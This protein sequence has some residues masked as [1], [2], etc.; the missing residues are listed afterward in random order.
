[1]YLAF[2][3]LLSA[4]AAS[5][6]EQGRATLSGRVYD[7]SEAIVPG[8]AV[9]VSNAATGEV[10]EAETD[11]QGAYSVSLLR[12]GTY[13]FAV[14]AGGFKPY[15][16]T[17]IALQAGQRLWMDA[18]LEVAEVSSAITVKA[19]P[20]ESAFEHP[21]RNFEEA[22]EMR[23]VRESSARDVGEALTRLDGVWKIRKG[24]IAN[25]VLLRGFQQDNVN[26][27]IDG[28]RIHGACP[29]RMDPPHPTWTS[30]KS[31][32]SKS[33]RAR[34]ISGTRAGSAGWSIS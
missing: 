20:L 15:T 3:L 11:R 28:A 34:S 18:A 1:M 29:N 4:P 32:R 22:L 26:V 5:A 27:L 8:V 30:R 13:D 7:P 17:G 6:A 10:F 24:G 33:S 21:A 14:H 16:K 9:R 25:D 2:I 19:A 23:E 31:R 12:P